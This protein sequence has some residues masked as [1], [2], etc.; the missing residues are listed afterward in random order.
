MLIKDLHTIFGESELAQWLTCGKE[1]V[2]INDI[3]K[4]ILNVEQKEEKLLRITAYLDALT[5]HSDFKSPNFATCSQLVDKFAKAIKTD[6]LPKQAR[7]TWQKVEKTYSRNLVMKQ[8]TDVLDRTD[9]TIYGKYPEYKCKAIDLHKYS[10]KELKEIFKHLNDDTR[11][12]DRVIAQKIIDAHG[13]SSHTKISKTVDASDVEGNIIMAAYPGKIEH[14]DEFIYKTFIERDCPLWITLNQVEEIKTM[15]GAFWSNA[16]LKSLKLPDSWT[17][18]N[19]T[20]EKVQEDSIS[21]KNSL[22][23]S[24]LIATNGKE[25]RKILHLHYTGWPDYQEAPDVSFLYEC[26]LQILKYM[27][28]L[29][30]DQKIGVNCAHGL[31]RTGIVTAALLTILELE[32]LLK[33]TTLD[34]AVLNIPERIYRLRHQRNFKIPGNDAQFIQIFQVVSKYIEGLQ[35]H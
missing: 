4:N 22:I 17:I 16:N 10:D 31:G 15:E 2:D 32:S 8:A 34:Q 23:P 13:S 19:T 21:T 27:K 29:K 25:T 5:N 3:S 30:D 14:L 6:P 24:V 18:T 33:S 28:D 12:K 1:E 26:I 11:K 35:N 20:D 9:T 7:D